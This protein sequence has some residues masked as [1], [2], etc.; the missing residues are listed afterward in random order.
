[1]KISLL[2]LACVPMA[3]LFFGCAGQQVKP[4]E[5]AKVKRVAVVG[6]DVLQ[7]KSVS[8]G[9]LL[10]LALKG[11]GAG[12]AEIKLATVSAHVEP[13]IADLERSLKSEKGWTVLAS[14]ELRKSPRYQA[15]LKSKTEG[16]QNR[17]AVPDRYDPF[18]AAEVLDSWAILS[19]SADELRLL[20][21]ELKVDAL[22]VGTATVHLNNSG[23]FSSLVGDGEYKPKADLTLL[24]IQGSSG[25][26]IF[27]KTVEGPAVEKGERNVVGM[28]DDAKL[29]RLAR[30]ATGLSVG[31]MLK[32]IPTRRQEGASY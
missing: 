8:G 6:F 30:V 5:I 32:E 21:N 9:D 27:T 3:L 28:A 12:G 25:E 1:M 16:F 13:M 2:S 14:A 23:L 11:K 19:T 29:N 18:R 22:I 17:P 26:K 7:Q 20:A 24:L 10:G 31:L 4:A 15:L